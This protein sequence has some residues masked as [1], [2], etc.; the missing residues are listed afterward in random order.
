MKNLQLLPQLK[1]SL[2]YLYVEHSKIDQDDRTI[3]VHDQSG[4]IRVPAAALTLLMLGPGTSITHAAV[5]VLAD[6]GCLIVWCGE[7][8]VR[9][10]AQGLGETRSAARTLWQ[11]KLWADPSSRLKVAADM[12]RKRFS[13]PLPDSLNIAE[14]RG[15]EGVRV[16]TAYHR[17]SDEFGVPWAGRE[18]DRKSWGSADPVNRA[19]SAANSCLY[20]LC[21]A[22]ILSAGFSPAIG[23]IHTG[24]M[25][26]FVYDVADLYKCDTTIPAAFEV[27]KEGPAQVESRVRRLLRDRFRQ[28]QLLDRIVADIEDLLDIDLSDQNAQVYDGDDDALPSGLWDPD[29]VVQGGVN[30]GAPKKEASSEEEGQDG[31]GCSRAG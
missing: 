3:S 23:F 17:A 27:A 31:S 19:L 13:E 14:L 6:V 30:Y 26:S 29:V 4:R 9:L 11:A 18:Y 7:E 15:H 21:H 28:T 5:H 2:S 25:L 20:G 12:Y 22:S 16:R 10:Y 1:D 8:S 24:K